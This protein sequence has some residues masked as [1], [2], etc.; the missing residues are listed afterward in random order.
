M[1][2]A[3]HLPPELSRS[4][5]GFARALVAAA[6]SVALYPGSHPAVASSLQRL[7][8]AVGETVAE[9]LV[10]LGVT[11]D[12]LLVG[13]VA[14]AGADGP[15][16]EAAALL[17]GR[18]ILQ[19]GFAGEVSVPTLQA[20]LGMLTLDAD[21][22]RARGGPARIWSD[23]GDA[24]I[25]IEQIDY[26]K[27]LE[28]REVRSPV[29]RKDELW[30]SIVQSVIERRKSLDEAAQR[31]LLEIAGDVAAI[32]DLAA[33]V[34]AP[35]YALDGSPMLT[36]QAAAVLAAYRH[37]T[38]I[39]SVLAP[40]RRDEVIGNLAAATANLDPH[41]VMQLLRSDDEREAG[42][43][44]AGGVGVVRGIAA[45]FDDLKVAQLLATTLALEGQASARLAEVFDTIAPDEPRKRRVLTLTRSLLTE[46][47][48]GRTDQFK[49]LWSSMEEL[50]VSYNERPFVSEQ[51]RAGLDE[52]GSRADAMAAQDLPPDI[53]EWVATLGQDNVRR[54]SVT[55]LIDLLNLERDARRAPELAR[56]VAGLAEDLLLAG[57]Y[58]AA[59]EVVTALARAA[60]DRQGVMSGPSR[61]ALDQLAGSAGL[62]EVAALF[63]DLE[64]VEFEQLRAICVRLGPAATDALLAAL[65][66]EDETR[67]RRRASDLIA[68]YGRAAV[69]RLAPLVGSG[70]WY[71][72]RNAADLLGRIA[73]PDAVPLLQPLLRGA[74]ARVTRAAVRALAAIDDPAAARAVHTVLRASTGE[75]RKAVVSA[76]V[77]EQD[78]RVVP[79]L[80]RILTESEPLGADHV[81]VLETLEALGRVGDDQAV[82][83]VAT[84]MRRRSWLARRKVRALKQ[85]SLDTLRGIG[86][87]AAAAA[88]D[89]AAQGGDRLLR[90]L[91][92][93]MPSVR[94]G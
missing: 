4:V 52:I 46:T 58:A 61:V 71:V 68:A 30:R 57:D 21:T 37:L 12:T 3:T 65:G 49:T 23:T 35:A 13:G 42:P 67:A 15:V 8:A 62:R 43:G 48:F 45:A 76:L 75:L 34:M 64:D 78:P 5:T 93:A 32:G 81:I 1:T 87:P 27:V 90:K 56:D 92:R 74:D 36:S 19:L 24:S 31:R 33:D 40:E 16:A 2:E 59:E 7:R 85:A 88:L 51:Y 18:D 17:H 54:L 77:A 63:G 94:H 69:S 22:L 82:P 11:P 28:D 50:L 55:L 80:V 66:V 41:V 9:G 6:R 14:L 72:Q 10:E 89:A 25:A 86:T 91:V 60:A 29:T 44:G 26:E 38:G 83:P 20:F 53:G 73:A 79:V 70:T 47:D 84:L 39:V